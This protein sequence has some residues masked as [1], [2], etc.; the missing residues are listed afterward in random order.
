MS[1]RLGFL[2]NADPADLAQQVMTLTLQLEEAAAMGRGLEERYK[3]SVALL[4]QQKEENDE[5][6]QRQQK[7]IDQVG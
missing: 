2:L 1:S 5:A 4:R 3:Q 6:N 7:F